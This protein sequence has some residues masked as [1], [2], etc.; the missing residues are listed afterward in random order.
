MNVLPHGLDSEQFIQSFIFTLLGFVSW[1]FLCFCFMLMISTYIHH[2]DLWPIK[3]KCENLKNS[4]LFYSSFCPRD[5]S[6][7]Y[8][9]VYS[10]LYSS[11]AIKSYRYL[12]IFQSMSIT[13]MGW[14]SLGCVKKHS[15]LLVELIIL[16]I[17]RQI[18]K[19]MVNGSMTHQKTHLSSCHTYSKFSR[20]ILACKVSCIELFVPESWIPGSVRIPKFTLF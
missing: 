20:Q 19:S 13:L 6:G 14:S 12:Y 1:P 3:C 16:V 10:S 2:I 8:Y 17:G 5:S 7:H 15:T 9:L 11:V 18:L 4:C